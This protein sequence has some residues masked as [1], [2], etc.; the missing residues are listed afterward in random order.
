MKNLSILRAELCLVLFLSIAGGALADSESRISR[1]ELIAKRDAARERVVQ[2]KEEEKSEEQAHPSRS[3]IL[4]RSVLLESG[5]Y[6]TFIPKGAV[7]FV[8]EKFS[9]RVNVASSAG[10]Y[11]PFS[12]FRAKN[13]GW[14]STYSVTLEQARGNDAISNDVRKVFANSGRV[15]VSVCKGGPISTRAPKNEQATVQK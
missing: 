4:D 5:R 10:K 12:E 1:E 7:L 2:V 13:R 6:W 9:K 8:P 14:L 15:V 11:I 3:S